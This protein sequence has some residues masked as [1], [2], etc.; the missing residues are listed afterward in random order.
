M[1]KISV[2][3]LS[4]LLE[5]EKMEVKIMSEAGET[6]ELGFEIYLSIQEDVEPKLEYLGYTAEV[7]R[8]KKTVMKKFKKLSALIKYLEKSELIKDGE[9]NVVKY[10]R[11]CETLEEYRAAREFDCIDMKGL[12]DKYLPFADRFSL[13]CP[14]SCPDEEHWFGERKLHKEQA[15]AANAKAEKVLTEQVKGVFMRLSESDKAKLPP[16]EKL[17]EDITREVH[18]YRAAHSGTAEQSGGQTFICDE[19][20]CGNTKYREPQ[21]LWQIYHSLDML[22]TFKWNSG[23]MTENENDVPIDAELNDELYAPL[24]RDLIN[25]EITY[26]WHCT[27]TSQLSKVF[28]FRLTDSSIAWLAARKNDYDMGLFEDL[29]FY[30]GDEL[31]FSSCT[32]EGFHNDLMRK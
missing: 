8:G 25:I 3:C 14:F 18:E 27:I 31:L 21:E 13:T 23:K 7:E 20:S 16:F 12:L 17:L 11:G 28:Y 29:A 2:D 10:P 24:A 19:F 4:K 6:C 9:V 5:D 15:A 30:K 1:Q 32:H 26:C 22:E